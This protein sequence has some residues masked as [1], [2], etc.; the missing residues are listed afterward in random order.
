MSSKIWI[1]VLLIGACMNSVHGAT[2]NRKRQATYGSTAAAAGNPNSPSF[3]LTAA[4]TE[5][6]PPI[7]PDIYQD[8]LLPTVSEYNIQLFLHNLTIFTI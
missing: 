4:Q 8:T 1:S 5:N 7:H 6:L 3:G 2:R